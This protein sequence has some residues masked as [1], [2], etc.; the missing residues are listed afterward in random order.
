MPKISLFH[1]FNLQIESILES[2]HMTGLIHFW[3]NQPVNWDT[4]PFLR[5]RVSVGVQRPD[6]LN[7]LR[8]NSSFRNY[9]I[10]LAGL[11]LRNKIFPKHRFCAGTQQIIN[12][13]IIEQIQW[14]S[15]TEFFFKFKKPIF[16]PFPQYLGQKKFFK[17]VGVMH[18]FIRVS[19]ILAKPREI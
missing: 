17:K 5:Y 10:W 7:L 18:N 15:M 14:K 6:L 19:S 2:H 1:L 4:N 13:F 12:T 9:A 8:R 11:H 16:G 3:S